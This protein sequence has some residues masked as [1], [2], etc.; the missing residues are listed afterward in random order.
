MP[1]SDRVKDRKDTSI[2]HR[3]KM[4][5][6][7]LAAMAAISSAPAYGFLARPVIFSALGA[8][9]KPPSGWL[10]FCSDNPAECRPAAEEPRDVVL[11]PDLLQQL[12]SINAYVNDRVKWTSDAELYGKTEHWAY[13]L[14]RGDCED[15]VLLKRRLLAGAGWPL[16]TLLITTVEDPAAKGERHAVLT[17]RTDRGEMILDNQTPEILFWYETNYQYL[18][19]Q[20]PADPNVWV[21]FRAEQPKPGATP[22]AR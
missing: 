21:S 1:T 5:A 4:I 7:S 17:I 13:P 14:D 22:T 11:T 16:G 3:W 2:A 15:I 12:F 6:A 20:S 18:T 9:T 19:R 8:V 10:Q